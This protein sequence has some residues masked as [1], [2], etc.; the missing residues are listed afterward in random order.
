MPGSP[1]CGPVFRTGSRAIPSPAT[2]ISTWAW[3]RLTGRCREGR[4]E[5]HTS[6]LQSLRHLVCRLLLEKKNSGSPRNAPR[7]E[8]L[9]IFTLPCL[10]I[11]RASQ[12]VTLAVPIRFVL[13]VSCHAFL[14]SS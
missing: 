2:L 7:E 4:S 8:T 5:E 9:T 11:C 14:H 3:R 13:I 1:T 6:E 12:M 10:I